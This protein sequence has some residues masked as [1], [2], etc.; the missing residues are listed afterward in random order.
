M[1]D[2]NKILGARGEERAVRYLKK[3]GYKILVKNYQLKC[4]EIDIIARYK[5]MLC[6]IEVKTRTSKAFGSPADAVTPAKQRQ[7]KR[8][9]QCYLKE[10]GL[11]EK[12][13]RFDV[14]SIIDDR[15]G[16]EEVDLIEDAFDA[17]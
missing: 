9:A 7:I 13:V 15:A 11:L 2:R 17:E 6:F 3:R 12:I 16:K 1:K 10:K 8:A 5:D 14:V 4:G